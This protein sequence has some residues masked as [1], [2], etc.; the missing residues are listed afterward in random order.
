M[1]HLNRTVYIVLYY[2]MSLF[3]LLYKYTDIQIL[4]S[5]TS[6]IYLLN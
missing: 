4:L 1:G 2:S 5:I 3:V 6:V